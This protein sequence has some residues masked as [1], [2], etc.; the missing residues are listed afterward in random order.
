MTVEVPTAPPPVAPSGHRHSRRAR[1]LP[2]WITIVLWIIVGALAVVA[3]ARIVAWDALDVLAV[4]NS[5]T[6]FLY[7]PAWVVAVVAM[8][9]RRYVL[10]GAALLVKRGGSRPCTNDEP[11][12]LSAPCL[13]SQRRRPSYRLWSTP[14]D[15]SNKQER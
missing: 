11:M 7:L 4:L 9:G 15:S 2:L 10:A 6:V 13:S 1:R 3:V 8:L 5:V 14:T 12:G